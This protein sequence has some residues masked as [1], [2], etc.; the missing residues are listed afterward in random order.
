MPRAAPVT[1]ACGECGS[2][3]TRHLP[4]WF[5][6]PFGF[7]YILYFKLWQTNPPVRGLREDPIQLAG[8]APTAIGT[9]ICAGGATVD[10]GSAACSVTAARLE[11]SEFHCSTPS[12]PATT[13]RIPASN[14]RSAVSGTRTAK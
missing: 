1:T 13:I 14:S 7:G 3:V 5:Q 11:P 10:A 12:L 2:F 4:E 9:T 8:R 6:R